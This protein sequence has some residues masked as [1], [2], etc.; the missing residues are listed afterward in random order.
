MANGEMRLV[1]LNGQTGD[2]CGDIQS[3]PSHSNAILSWLSDLIGE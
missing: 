3:R 2:A 1:L